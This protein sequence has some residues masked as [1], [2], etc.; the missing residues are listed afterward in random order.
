MDP[1]LAFIMANI[2]KVCDVND[3]IILDS[4]VHI[5]FLFNFLH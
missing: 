1:Q 5:S 4:S 3:F 2:A